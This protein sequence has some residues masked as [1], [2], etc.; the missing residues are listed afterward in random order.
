MMNCPLC[1][2]AAH[3]RSSFPVTKETKER[4]YHCQNIN[5]CCSFVSME[6]VVRLITKPTLVSYAHPHPEPGG[7]GHM[8]F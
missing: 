8:N 7:Q 4:Y 2:H 6:T 3:T 5:C 1:G